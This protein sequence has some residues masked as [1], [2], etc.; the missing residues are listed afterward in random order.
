MKTLIHDGDSFSFAFD[1]FTAAPKAGELHFPG[2]AENEAA[3]DLNLNGPRDDAAAA[4]GLQ[5]I[6]AKR[7]RVPR[8]EAILKE[9]HDG[10]DVPAVIR[11]IVD[12]GRWVSADVT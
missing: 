6:P 12:I 3:S 2:I 9:L 11:D 1:G 7:P 4:S 5:L 8:V 10:R